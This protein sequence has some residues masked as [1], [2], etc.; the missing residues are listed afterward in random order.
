MT[1][2]LSYLNTVA[3]PPSI[4]TITSG[5]EPTI[6][7]DYDCAV[8]GETF[9]QIAVIG[10]GNYPITCSGG[11]IT[12]DSD[13]FI[14]TPQFTTLTT[15]AGN[16]SQLTITIVFRPTSSGLKTATYTVTV[17]GTNYSIP[18][19]ATAVSPALAIKIIGGLTPGYGAATNR[20]APCVIMARV[21]MLNSALPAPFYECYFKWVITP[22][23]SE[24]F[25]VTDTRTFDTNTKNL[26]NHY[27]G[28]SIA[29]PVLEGQHGTWGIRCYGYVP[30]DD[31]NN[32]SLDSGNTNVTV[33]ALGTTRATRHVTATGRGTPDGLSFANAWSYADL[34]ANW[35]NDLHV[36]LYDDDGDFSH[37]VKWSMGSVENTSM[38]AASGDSPT[39]SSSLTGSNAPILELVNPKGLWLQGLSEYPT[40]TTQQMALDV[41]YPVECALYD[42]H[43]LGDGLSAGAHVGNSFNYLMAFGQ[44]TS[45]PTPM[46]QWPEGFALIK[47][48]GAETEG[49]SIVGMAD[50]L[51]E[52]G[53]YFKSSVNE[54][55][56]RWL[57]EGVYPVGLESRPY[58]D[59]GIWYYNAV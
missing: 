53:S 8:G 42:H 50:T 20:E 30:G 6:S 5:S 29:V 32:P 37:T 28:V 2:T 25:N 49:Y 15:G 35:A 44:D 41:Q 22:P 46:T 9:I 18:L 33:N 21:D 12:G 19:E 3:I 58:Q 34:R 59:K 27:P 13:F 38:V 11:A 43:F 55:C 45:Y 24:Q 31:G 40:G 1:H 14:R 10:T 7:P 16:K 57:A 51:V 23:N 47:C 54:S 52:V 4:D 39:F 36:I 26:F 48:T 56:C 17:E